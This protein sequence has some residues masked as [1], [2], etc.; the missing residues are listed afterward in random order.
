VSSSPRT[1]TRKFAKYG[2]AKYVY[3]KET[4]GEL[5]T[6]FEKELAATL[7]EARTLYWT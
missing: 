5:R 7:P 6:W 3:P 2:S 1:R 4:M